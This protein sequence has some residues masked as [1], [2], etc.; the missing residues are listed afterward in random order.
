MSE[1]LKDF[2]RLG[3]AAIVLALF[4]AIAIN[5]QFDN[6]FVSI[7]KKITSVEGRLEKIENILTEKVAGK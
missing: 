4:V 5:F 3:F 6:R 2:L 7:D 1:S